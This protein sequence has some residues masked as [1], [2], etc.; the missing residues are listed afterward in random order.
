MERQSE[1]VY[2][3]AQTSQQ[4]SY[5]NY[6]LSCL[7]TQTHVEGIFRRY[8]K[9][10]TSVYKCI[11]GKIILKRNFKEQDEGGW[12]YLGQDRGRRRPLVKTV[13]N[14]RVPKNTGNFLTSWVLNLVF[15]GTAPWNVVLLHTVAL[16]YFQHT[17]QHMHL[18]G[19][20]NLI[21]FYLVHMLVN[22]LHGV[23]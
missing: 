22:V 20:N 6:T 10:W 9:I 8:F 23:T 15:S 21:A 11:H 7:H 12:T 4:L 1:K 18:M 14:P 13:M 5:R 16:S 2:Q 17:D 19:F 3:N